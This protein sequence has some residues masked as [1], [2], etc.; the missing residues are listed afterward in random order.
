MRRF[1]IDYVHVSDLE[2]FYPCLQILILHSGSVGG[3]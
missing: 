2:S 1:S 3:D